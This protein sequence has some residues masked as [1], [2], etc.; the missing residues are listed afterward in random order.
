MNPKNPACPAIVRHRRTTAGKSCRNYFSVLSDCMRGRLQL[1]LKRA[2][3]RGVVR[4]T[5]HRKRKQQKQAGLVLLLRL[6]VLVL[7][8]DLALRLFGIPSILLIL[9]NL[10]LRLCGLCVRPCFLMSSLFRVFVIH[11]VSFAL[12]LSI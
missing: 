10:S 4:S 5:V 1:R 9:S 2:P 12:P 11:E 6:P 8:Q 7:S 3:L